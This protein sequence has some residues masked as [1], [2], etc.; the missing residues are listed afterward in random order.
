MRLKSR[1]Y[2]ELR[3]AELMHTQIERA[4]ITFKEISKVYNDSKK[5]IEKN[6]K[7]IFNKFSLE[8]GLT[9]KEADQVVNIMRSKKASNL[10]PALNL[11][12]LSERVQQVLKDLN[13]PAYVSRI[14]RL[15]NLIDEIDN[16]RR[17]IAKHEISKTTD[18]YKDVAK[19]GYY[20]NIHQMQIQTGIGFSFNTLDED[21]VE[22][23]IRTP[24]NGR[25]YSERIWNNTQKLSET[26]KDEVLQAVLTGKKEKAVTDELINRFN[27]SEFE[28]K[29]LIR[30]ETAHIN[31]EMEAL[32]YEEAD[33][34]KYRFVAVLDTRTSHICREHDYKVYKVSERQVGVNYPPLHPFCRSTTIAVFNDDDLT[35]LS[36]RARDPKTGKTTTI[37]GDMDYEDWYNQ[38]VKPKEIVVN[39]NE[40][41]YNKD[42]SHREALDMTKT[43]LMAKSKEFKTKNSF[44]EDIRFNA[45]KVVGTDY[46]IWLQDNTKKIR[47]TFNL[48]EN[49]L[50]GFDNIPRIVILKEQKLK[51]IAGYNRID[52]TLYISDV[53]HS[54]KNINEVLSNGYFASKNLKDILTHELAHKRH[55]DSA[56]KLYNK[57]KKRYN[58]V[59]EAKSDLDSQLVN[60]V[61]Q[62]ENT[63][64]FYV[65]KISKNANEAWRMRNINELVAEVKVLGDKVEDKEL[66]NKVK[67]V[68]KW[69]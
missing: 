63:D 56:K 8:Y 7:G 38:Y 67:G 24:W 36:R 16:V 49:E 64:F 48:V 32:S 20:N 11:M 40:K 45:K 1:E 2:W 68:L 39:A 58:N 69:K 43:D 33:I 50:K 23:L 22:R 3:K 13:S 60:Y 12:P 29:R 27:V 61:K 47:D 65:R 28:S 55:W 31:N 15:Q 14:N 21:L 51:G 35:E 6:V 57:K 26:L 52:D 17:Y 34:E 25:N 4:D 30:T 66:L 5:H 54:E 9:K 19:H 44:N 18:L 53:L 46:D 37:P 42:N 10:V 62:Q 59:E 41:V